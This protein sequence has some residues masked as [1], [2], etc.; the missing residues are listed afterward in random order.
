[1]YYLTI[2]NNNFRQIKKNKY[3]NNY[4]IIINKEI[5]VISCN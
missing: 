2:I 4:S 3:L 5:Y 1:M